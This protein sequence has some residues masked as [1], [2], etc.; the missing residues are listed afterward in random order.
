[1][2]YNN[3]RLDEAAELF[4]RSIAMAPSTPE[5]TAAVRLIVTSLVEREDWT[6]ARAWALDLAGVEGLAPGV[7]E[8]LLAL[9]DEIAPKAG[10]QARRK[11][12]ERRR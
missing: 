6:T 11:R 8:R 1:M 9:A 5:A 3:G 12:R 4:S 10:K 2:L 7:R